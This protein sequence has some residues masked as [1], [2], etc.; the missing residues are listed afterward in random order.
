VATRVCLSQVLLLCPIWWQMEQVI[1]F[2]VSGVGLSSS[3][4]EENHFNFFW[5]AMFLDVS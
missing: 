3:N 5:I 2:V 1:S 4:K